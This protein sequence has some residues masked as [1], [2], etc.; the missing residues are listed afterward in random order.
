MKKNITI[1]GSTGSIGTQALEVI[2][3]LKDEFNIKAISC[4]SNINL[5]KKQIETFSPEK[6]CVKSKHDCELLKNLYKNIS[7][8]FGDE[9]IN[10][11]CEDKT[12]DIIIVAV[13]GKIGLK[14]TLTAIKNGINIALANK[15]TLIM[16]GDIVMEKARQNKVKI[17]PVDSEH[18]AIHQC[19]KNLIMKYPDGS[20]RRT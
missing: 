10:E 1:L 8:T 6:V 11:L 20:G 4:G 9:G 14:P 19:I 2:S 12:N 13:S 16:A 5:F 17:L 18:S 3:K 7:F 15:E